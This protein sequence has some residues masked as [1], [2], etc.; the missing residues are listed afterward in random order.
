MSALS[1]VATDVGIP[2]DIVR[3][4]VSAKTMVTIRA[5]TPQP[6]TKD[7]QCPRC[8]LIMPHQ[9]SYKVSFA[10]IINEYAAKHEVDPQSMGTKNFGGKASLS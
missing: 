1:N 3:H 5:G 8:F 7:A 10:M 2:K 4:R 9:D 6:I